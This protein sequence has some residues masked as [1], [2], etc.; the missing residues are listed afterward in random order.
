M[1][2]L[3]RGVRKM[4]NVYGRKGSGA[5]LLTPDEADEIVDNSEGLALGPCTCRVVFGNCDS[6]IN[7]EIMVGVSRSVFIEERPHDYREIT[8]Q[9]AK[10]VLRQCRRNG[11]VHTIIKC[12]K[13][14]YAICS[15]CSC[16]CVPMRLKKEYGIGNALNR[17]DDILREF[18]T[19]QVGSTD[20][21]TNPSG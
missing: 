18:S 8:K 16:C 20:R 3:G 12:R 6:P 14:F 1:P 4:A 13:D 10:E 17:S 21:E 9:E 11:L 19:R 5:Y 15:C 2:L 7:T